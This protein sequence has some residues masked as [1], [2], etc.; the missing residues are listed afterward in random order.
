MA[1]R[2]DTDALIAQMNTRFTQLAGHLRG[3]ESQLDDLKST[4]DDIYEEQAEVAAAVGI[5]LGHD[6]THHDDIDAEC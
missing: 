3:I 1:D 5:D 4:I 6:A 2:I